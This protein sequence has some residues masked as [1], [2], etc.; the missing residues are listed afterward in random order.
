MGAPGAGGHAAHRARTR[1][2]K[3]PDLV[4]VAALGH[5]FGPNRQRGVFR[6]KD[7]GKSWE[8]VLFKSEDAGGADLSIDAT[9]PRIMYAS[10]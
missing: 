2:S 1:S 9:N 6:S 8:H 4:Y 7:G 10:L 3:D 5:A